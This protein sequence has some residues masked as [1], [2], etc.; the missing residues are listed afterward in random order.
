MTTEPQLIDLME[1]VLRLMQAHGFTAID[2][3]PGAAEVKIDAQWY[4]AVNGHDAEIEVTP[5][6]CM[7]VSLRPYHFVVWYNGWLAG[8]FHPFGGSLAAGSA[9]NEGAL[10]AAIEKHIADLGAL[11]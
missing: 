3:L 10:C 1:P 11:G 8:L 5:P 2:Q 4:L 7:S 6:D 9:A